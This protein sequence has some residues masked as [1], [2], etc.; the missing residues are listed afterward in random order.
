MPKASDVRRPRTARGTTPSIRARER[1]DQRVSATEETPV[2]TDG[3][4][5]G[6]ADRDGLRWMTPRTPSG[7]RASFNGEFD[8]GSGR[9]LAAGLTHASRGTNRVLALGET[10]E[11]VSNT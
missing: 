7:A 10:G 8:P 11:R 1:T 9:T 6:R 4:R 2:I 3:A 5:L